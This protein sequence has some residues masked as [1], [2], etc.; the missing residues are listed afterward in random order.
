MGK[1]YLS[2]T[3]QT[4]D[5]GPALYNQ[6]VAD[7]VAFD[8]SVPLAK[9]TEAAEAMTA[10]HRG[11]DLF[12]LTSGHIGDQ[13]LHFVVGADRKLG[14]DEKHRIEGDVYRLVAEPGSS[15]SAEHGIGIAKKPYLAM[16]RSPVALALMRDL[17]RTLDPRGILNPGRVFDL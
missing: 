14:A 1:A 16:S 13:N 3:E 9:I 15:I 2:G 5:E 17:K 11:G 4:R 6:V 10:P 12:P 7:K 8:I